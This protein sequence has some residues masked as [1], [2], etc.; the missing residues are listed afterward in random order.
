MPVKFNNPLFKT[1]TQ[2]DAEILAP[3]VDALLRNN[4]AAIGKTAS[5]SDIRNLLTP[6]EAAKM[7]RVVFNQ[8][9]QINGYEIINPDD[10]GA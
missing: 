8:I 6:A 3:V 10:E 9:C 1:Q 4:T 2:I 7:S 5:I